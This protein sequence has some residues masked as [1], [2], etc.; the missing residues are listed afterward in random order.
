[1]RNWKVSAGYSLQEAEVRSATTA[2]PAANCEVAQVPR[3][4]ASLWNRYDVTSRIGLG[5]GVYHQS[6]SFASIS[7]AVV[8]PSYARVDAAAFF[9]IADGVEAQVNVE[10]L[11]GEDYFATAHNDNNITPGAPTTVRGTVRFRF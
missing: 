10:N 6:K 3:H 2:C 8:I 4:T 7:N 11:L 9:E 1:V 5:L